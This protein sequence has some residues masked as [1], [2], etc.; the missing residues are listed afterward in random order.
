MTKAEILES[1]KNP[2]KPVETKF[3]EVR[4]Q[5]IKVE[6]YDDAYRNNTP[7]DNKR[8]WA[9]ACRI[10]REIDIRAQLREAATVNT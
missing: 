10:A 4:G 6:F 8:I 9:N 1:I 5:R 7:E 3:I 2:G